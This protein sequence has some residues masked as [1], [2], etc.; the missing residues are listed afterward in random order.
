MELGN[1]IQHHRKRLGLSQTALAERIYVTRQTISNWETGHSYPDVENLLLLGATFDISLDELV[2]GD[3]AEMKKTVMQQQ[4][5]T[6]TKVMLISVGLALLAIAPSL[7]LPDYWWAVPPFLL[8][9][10]GMVASLKVERLKRRANIKTYQ[11]ILAFTQNG[12]LQAAR[13]QRNKW[14][15]F[16]QKTLIVVTFWLVCAILAVI[17]CL[18]YLFMH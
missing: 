14:R 2:K 6:Y 7:F 12:D 8:W 4:M 13:R 5:D 18:P 17:A 3:V 10:V 1:Q 15:D 9:S 16:W 11:E